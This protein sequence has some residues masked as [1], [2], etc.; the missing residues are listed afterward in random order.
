MGLLG[1]LLG[2]YCPGWWG[3]K[4]VKTLLI[5]TLTLTTIM[6]FLP[7]IIYILFVSGTMLLGGRFSDV[8]AVAK[9]VSNNVLNVYYAK[10]YPPSQYWLSSSHSIS[11]SLCLSVSLSLLSLINYFFACLSRYKPTLP[12]LL[13]LSGEEDGGIPGM[14]FPYVW[15]AVYIIYRFIP[16]IYIGL[17]RRCR[18]RTLDCWVWT[19]DR[20]P[21]RSTDH[22]NG[23]VYYV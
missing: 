3:T 5:L 23:I 21:L 18:S 10:S 4:Y 22:S 20:W 16:Y 7:C 12:R 11:L 19:V 15:M 8:K 17:Y 13:V 9:Y 6:V 2:D 14:P 1:D